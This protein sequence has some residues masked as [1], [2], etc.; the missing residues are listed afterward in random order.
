MTGEP[1][2]TGKNNLTMDAL[3]HGQS[4]REQRDIKVGWCACT[5]LIHAC[6]LTCTQPI[7]RDPYVPQMSPKQLTPFPPK[8][9][10]HP[11][12]IFVLYHC[13]KN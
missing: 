10:W 5:D 12:Q 1:R 2:S 11:T 7:A 9:V 3:D 8:N 4:K 13:S 6:P